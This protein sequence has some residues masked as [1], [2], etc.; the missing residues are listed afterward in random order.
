MVKEI[1]QDDIMAE[2]NVTL[3][4]GTELVS[5]IT[6]EAANRIGVAPGKEVYVI[7]KSTDVMLGTDHG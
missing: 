3:P 2:V 4:G 6:A 7:I 1:K 5:V